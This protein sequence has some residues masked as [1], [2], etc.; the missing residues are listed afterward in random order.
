MKPW[1][2]FPVSQRWEVRK[3]WG[4]WVHFPL[5]LVLDPR[6]GTGSAFEGTLS[7]TVD[8]FGNIVAGRMS[9]CLLSPQL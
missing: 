1:I 4:D 7:L 5:H 8:I 6:D 2:L 9:L 3:G